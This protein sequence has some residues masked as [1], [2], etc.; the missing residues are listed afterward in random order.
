MYIMAG[1]FRKIID[2]MK[3][4]LKYYNE[5]YVSYDIYSGYG[6]YFGDFGMQERKKKTRK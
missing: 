3:E 2:W 4:G 5:S 1:F 6:F